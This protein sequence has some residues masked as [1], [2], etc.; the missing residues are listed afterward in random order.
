MRGKIFSQRPWFG[1][2]ALSVMIF[3][4]LSIIYNP[5][6][7]VLL[8]I[9]YLLVEF[10]VWPNSVKW[11]EE[12]DNFGIKHRFGIGSG[13]VMFIAGMLI[14]PDFVLLLGIYLSITFYIVERELLKA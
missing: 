5:I 12:C 3:C 13:L 2:Y 8:V 11:V 4:I 14:Y 7:S 6:I 9:P 10:C 1:M